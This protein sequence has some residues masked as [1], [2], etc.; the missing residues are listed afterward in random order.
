MNSPVAGAPIVRPLTDTLSVV[1]ADVIPSDR[2][3]GVEWIKNALAA[4]GRRVTNPEV[5]AAAAKFVAR[6][7]VVRRRRTTRCYRY[8]R[9]PFT[10]D[11]K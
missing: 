6:G 3:V 11:V 9:S 10:G 2:W 4:R 1:V 8:R 7:E 5:H